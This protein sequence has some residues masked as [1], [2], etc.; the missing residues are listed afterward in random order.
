MR[1]LFFYFSILIVAGVFLSS[2][3]SNATEKMEQASRAKADSLKE[4]KNL[5]SLFNA[6]SKNV[7]SAKSN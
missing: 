3:G 4:Q 2:C 5:D 1:K 7:D 6:A